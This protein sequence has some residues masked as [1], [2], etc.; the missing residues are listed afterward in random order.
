[1]HADKKRLNGLSGDAIGCAFTVRNT[2]GAGFLE[3]GAA[4]Q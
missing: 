1:M 4:Q 3:K 2:L